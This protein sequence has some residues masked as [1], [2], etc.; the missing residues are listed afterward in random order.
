M[1]DLGLACVKGYLKNSLP[2]TPVAVSFRLYEAISM[3][4]EWAR[5]NFCGMQCVA[6]VSISDLP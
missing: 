6:S 1:L 3:L 2:T 4:D 5:W